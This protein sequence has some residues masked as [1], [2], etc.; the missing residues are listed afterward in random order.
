M[1]D[2]DLTFTKADGAPFTILVTNTFTGIEGE[3]GGFAGADFATGTNLIDNGTELGDNSSAPSGEFVTAN[4][5]AA[6]ETFS[7]AVDDITVFTFTSTEAGDF[8]TAEDVQAG[9]NA[10]A[11]ELTTAGFTVSGT[12]ADGDLVFTRLDGAPFEITVVNEFTG[13]VS[14][15]G[16]FTGDDFATGIQTIDNGRLAGPAP[17]LSSQS[18]QQSLS[19]GSYDVLAN[20]A[21][22]MILTI[23]DETITAQGAVTQNGEF[24]AL[25]TG[26]SNGDSSRQGRGILFLIRQPD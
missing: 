18:G 15:A 5:G 21:V 13:T 26:T 4:A 11:G 6:D 7:L 8:V 20:G 1:V 14:I 16:G 10:A 19:S 22:T 9:V 25:A 23:G 2:G 24:I 3:A 12:V 17:S